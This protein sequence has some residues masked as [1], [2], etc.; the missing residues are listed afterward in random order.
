MIAVALAACK[1]SEP[2]RIEEGAIKLGTDRVVQTGPLGE[3]GSDGE[4][5]FVLVDADNVTDHDLQVIL[6]GTLQD[7]A[8]KPVGTLRRESLRIPSKGRRTFALIDADH[9]ARPD[10]TTAEVLVVSS[11]RPGSRSIARLDDVHLFDDHGRVMVAANL[12]NDSDH[13]GTLL[14]FAGF[15]DAAGKPMQRQ[16]SVQEIGPHVTQVVRFTG[17]LGSKTGYVFLGDAIY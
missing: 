7:A 5:T 13:P 10:A 3:P 2:A 1:G 8:G 4:A 14:V 15:H 16:F 9:A 11:E 12:T 6:G 17:P